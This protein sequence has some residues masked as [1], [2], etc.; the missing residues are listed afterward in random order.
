[1][2]RREKLILVF[3]LVFVITS[4]L[5]SN[6]L[7]APKKISFGP[8]LYDCSVPSGAELQS[9][10]TASGASLAHFFPLETY[11]IVVEN[12]YSANRQHA[13]HELLNVMLNFS[14]TD[15]LEGGSGKISQQSFLLLGIASVVK[16]HTI[17]EIGLN[18][19]HS[20][21]TWLSAADLCTVE[22][23]TCVYLDLV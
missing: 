16:P 9:R 7:F 2:G 11:E 10:L 5:I 18:M 8:S 21:A 12:K 14:D 23:Q 6:T 15:E 22:V 1:M 4:L 20:M 17:C 19:G 3:L 13:L